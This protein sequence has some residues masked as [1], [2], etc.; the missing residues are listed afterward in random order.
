MFNKKS[1]RLLSVFLCAAALA[2]GV[3]ASSSAPSG[4]RPQRGDCKSLTVTLD[5]LAQAP[6]IYSATVKGELRLS[7]D[8]VR[9]NR[10]VV[11]GKSYDFWPVTAISQHAAD[12]GMKV[13]SFIEA[14]KITD[15][16]LK[17]AQGE[18]CEFAYEKDGRTLSLLVFNAG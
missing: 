14:H 16:P 1:V 8:A 11:S 12:V 7:L 15:L 5:V 2:S 18:Q 9:T 6:D 3:S 4:L 10:V 13:E 17:T